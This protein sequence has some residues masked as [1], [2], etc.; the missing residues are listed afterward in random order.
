MIGVRRPIVRSLA[1]IAAVAA[2]PS[3]TGI[4]TSIST[5]S[6][7][8]RA[9][10]LFGAVERL[11]SGAGVEA[12]G[13]EAPVAGPEAEGPGR[14]WDP[15][16]VLTSV[17]GDRELMGRL[18]ERFGG[19]C[20]G[21]LEQIREAVGR[22]DARAVERGA[23]KLKGSVANFSARGAIEAARRLEEIGRG[24]ALEGA[25]PALEAL[26]EEMG[27]LRGAMAEYLGG[28]SDADPDRRG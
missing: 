9:A 2:K 11:L 3:I 15:D 25:G 10:E 21:L 7:P 18:I 22:G 12:A 26:E 27:R 19:Q 20:P 4:C 5:T 17:E 23:H 8:L 6:K 24:G 28:G 13:P 1:R 16:A 14:A